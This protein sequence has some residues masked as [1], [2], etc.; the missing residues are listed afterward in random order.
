MTAENTADGIAAG[1][2]RLWA[3][4]RPREETLRHAEAFGWDATTQGQLS[5]FRRVAGQA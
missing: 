2:R 4:M 3:G 1:V 5:L